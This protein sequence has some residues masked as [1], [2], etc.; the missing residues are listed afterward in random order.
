[1]E[2]IFNYFNRVNFR[3]EDLP[4]ILNKIIDVDYY[5]LLLNFILL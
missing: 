3:E 2:N 4:V 1:M 5:I